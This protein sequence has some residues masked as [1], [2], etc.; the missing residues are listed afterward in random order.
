MKKALITLLA[1]A[2]ISIAVIINFSEVQS[3]YACN[4]VF[5]SGEDNTKGKIFIKLNEYRFWVA[6]WSYNKSDGNFH[7]E[8]PN[9]LVDYY[10]KI[11]KVGDQIQIYE[12]DSIAGNFSKLSKTLAIKTP[13]GF[14]DGACENLNN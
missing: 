4:G 9:E 3:R 6:L 10:S 5:S 8:I 11:L 2:A 14:F 1:I 7:T 12:N 13:K